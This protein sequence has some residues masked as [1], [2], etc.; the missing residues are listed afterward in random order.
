M[1]A[2]ELAEKLNKVTDT[3]QLFMVYYDSDAINSYIYTTQG[4]I[5]LANSKVD[6]DEPITEVSSAVTELYNVDED[7]HIMDVVSLVD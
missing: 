7:I 2:K 1:N 5:E 6:T 4:L 3:R